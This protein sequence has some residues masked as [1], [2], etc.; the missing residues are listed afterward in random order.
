[1]YWSKPDE[2]GGTITKY[3]IYKK[4]ILQDGW[5]VVKE[6]PSSSKSNYKTNVDGLKPGYTYSFIITAT[7]EHGT[8]A[9]DD[10]RAKTVKI[11]ETTTPTATTTTANSM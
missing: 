7:N 2:N 11:I 8:S 10:S 9:I 3:T 4:T 5:S 6:V 1:L